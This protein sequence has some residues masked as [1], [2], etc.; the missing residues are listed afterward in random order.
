MLACTAQLLVCII[1]VQMY[2]CTFLSVSQRVRLPVVAAKKNE[3]LFS[4]FIEV[5]FAYGFNQFLII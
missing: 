2:I 4:L 5:S 3:M 1:Q